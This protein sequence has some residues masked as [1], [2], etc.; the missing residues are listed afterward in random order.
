MKAKEL[1]EQY[2]MSVLTGMV[3]AIFVTA[4]NS[5]LSVKKA[6]IFLA[7]ALLVF[8]FGLL[9]GFIAEDKPKSRL[10]KFYLI[11][12]WVILMMILVIIAIL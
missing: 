11:L 12:M 7:Y 2:V 3:A 8:V 4:V 9:Y 1:M 10:D 6:Y 5:D